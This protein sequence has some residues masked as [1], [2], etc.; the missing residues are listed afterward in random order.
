MSPNGGPPQLQIPL[1]ALIDALGQKDLEILM[2]RSQVD[3]LNQ[4]LQALKATEQ[5]AM[6]MTGH[7]P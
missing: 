7:Q 4:Q 6:H 5:A 2:L 3:D 1:P